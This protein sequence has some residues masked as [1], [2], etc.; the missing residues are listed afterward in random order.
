M[1]CFHSRLR[2][3]PVRMFPQGVVLTQCS[4]FIGRAI[5]AAGPAE[6]IAVCEAD[7]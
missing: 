7:Y 2:Q 3:G 6:I 5:P 4:A 1:M